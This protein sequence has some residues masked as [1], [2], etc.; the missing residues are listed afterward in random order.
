MATPPIV[1][2]YN[3]VSSCGHYAVVQGYSPEEEMLYLADPRNGEDY[4]LSFSEFRKLW[5]DEENTSRGWCLIIGRE[6]IIIN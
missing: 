1:N 6:K 4:T 3:P 5:H 2:Y